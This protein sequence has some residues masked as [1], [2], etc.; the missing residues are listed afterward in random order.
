MVIP[1]PAT[2]QYGMRPILTS[3]A[4]SVVGTSSSAGLIPQ[5]ANL[6]QISLGAAG[7]NTSGFQYIST[8]NAAVI[9]GGMISSTAAGGLMPAAGAGAG[10]VPMLGSSPAKVEAVK[11]PWGWKRL[12]INNAIV[13]FRY[14]RLY[15]KNVF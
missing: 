9:G 6:V 2:T 15:S 4:A 10:L 5:Q 13:Y 1:S 14:T 7:Q 12:C 3:T 8:V 11:V